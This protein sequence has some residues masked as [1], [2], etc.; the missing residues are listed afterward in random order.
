VLRGGFFGKLATASAVLLA[1]STPAAGQTRSEG[2]KFLQAV[3]KKDSRAINELLNAPGS[4]LINSRDLATNRTALH[5]MVEQRD[6]TWLEFLLKRGADPNLA[7]NRRVT[8]LLL[9]CRTGFL[10][11]VQTLVK[12][13]ARVDEPN[14]AGETPLIYAVHS[15]DTELM[16]I[17]LQ[18]GANPDR[19][20]N[21]GRSARDYARLEGLQSRVWAELERSAKPSSARSSSS[22]GPSF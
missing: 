6:Q 15:R 16:R 17:L 8:P 2:H 18:A 21:T 22:Y 13:G 12:G 11:G 9:A 5:I 14:S 3:E 19:T 4:T 10:A 1:L 7:D 20:D